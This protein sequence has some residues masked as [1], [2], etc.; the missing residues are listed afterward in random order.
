MYH[1][2]SYITLMAQ[3]LLILNQTEMRSKFKTKHILPG[4][5]MII[6]LIIINQAFYVA[7]V[8]NITNELYLNK[9]ITLKHYNQ[10]YQLA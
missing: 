2:F 6:I 7:I 3:A 9:L 1:I 4:A 10:K 5:D 8:L